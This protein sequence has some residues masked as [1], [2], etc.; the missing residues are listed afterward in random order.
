MG[1]IVSTTSR[2]LTPRKT[3]CALSRRLVGPRGPSAMTI[4][5]STPHRHSPQDLLHYIYIPYKI[6]VQTLLVHNITNRNRSMSK[7]SGFYLA[8][9]CLESWQ[10]V[11]NVAVGQ[12]SSPSTSA[13]LSIITALIQHTQIRSSATAL[14][15]LISDNAFKQTAN[16][17]FF[18]FCSSIALAR[19]FDVHLFQYKCAKIF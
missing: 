17:H 5:I 10:V 13:L 9:N 16:N 3:W 4:N 19:Y 2:C 11:V 15:N 18:I 14:H 8:E 6:T 12:F 7:V 1:R